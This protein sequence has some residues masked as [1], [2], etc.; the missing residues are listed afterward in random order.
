MTRRSEIVSWRSPLA[1]SSSS[2]SASSFSSSFSASSPPPSLPTA[3]GVAGGDFFS[4]LI[5]NFGIPSGVPG[6]PLLLGVAGVSSSSAPRP[7]A[8]GEVR[9]GVGARGLPWPLRTLRLALSCS[10]TCRSSDLRFSSSEVTECSSVRTARGRRRAARMGGGSVLRGGRASRR[11]D[12]V[13]A[14]AAG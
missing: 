13:T 3:L 8:L 2:V 14:G 10:V 9:G 7:A 5:G 12:C 6:V 4:S 11:R 1:S